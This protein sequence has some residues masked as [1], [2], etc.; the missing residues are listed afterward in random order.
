[1]NTSKEF[2]IYELDEYGNKWFVASFAH[3]DRAHNYVPVMQQ[4][5]PHVTY[6]IE[7]EFGIRQ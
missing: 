4:K 7:N 6:I 2:R 5:F 1:M 3:L